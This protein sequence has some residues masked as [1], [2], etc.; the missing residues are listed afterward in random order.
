MSNGPLHGVRVI[1]WTHMHQGPAGG[2]YLAELGADVIHVEQK[3]VGDVMR[4]SRTICGVPVTLPGDRNVFFED[5][6]KNK[7][8]ISID[9]SK[10]QGKEIMYRLVE[11]A[12]VFLTNY[13]PKAAQKLGLDYET[14]RGLN[15]RLVYGLATSYGDR[16]PEKD[17][18]G[19]EM[20]AFARSG[21]LFA[22][23]QGDAGPTSLPVAS[24][25]RIGGVFLAL[26]AVTR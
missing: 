21:I 13:R 8:G 15:T 2:M 1:D 14:L 24:G 11:K 22:N 23:G 5:L 3:G 4:G 6:N 9:L 26:G 19:I 18:P 7:R 10:P 20:G 16:G 17:S 25:D 12:D